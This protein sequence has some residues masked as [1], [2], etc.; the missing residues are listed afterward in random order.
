MKALYYISGLVLLTLGSC[1]SGLYVG[2]EY[3]DLYFQS[4][5][6]PVT[7]VRTRVS[8]PVAEGN[9][10]SAVERVPRA[11]SGAVRSQRGGIHSEEPA[12]SAEETAGQ[13]REGDKRVLH[14]QKCESSE[15]QSQDDKD[16]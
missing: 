8:Q 3:D 16:D 6:Q 15:D 1:S 14:S 5:D 12:K 2:T 11:F 10:Q 9:L 13:E 7:Q 4:S